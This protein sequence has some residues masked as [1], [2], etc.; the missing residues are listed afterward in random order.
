M[1]GV[2]EAFYDERQDLLHPEKAIERRV[3]SGE[4]TEVSPG[5]YRQTT[6]WDTYETFTL[7]SSG[8]LVPQHNLDETTG[9]VALAYRAGAPV[10]HELGTPIPVGTTD[11]DTVLKLGH[12]GWTVIQRPVLFS[13]EDHTATFVDAVEV[14]GHFVNLRDDTYVPLGVVGSVYKPFQN[15]DAM[16]FLQDLTGTF[17]LTWES[18]GATRGGRRVFVSVSLPDTVVI[19][20]EGIH[21]EIEL[22]IAVI[23]SHDGSSPLT[24][25]VTPW[26]P[27]CGN[28]ERFAVRDAVYRW[29]TRHTKNAKARTDEARRTLGLTLKYRARFA[30]EENRLAQNA[31]LIDEFRELVAEMFPRDEQETKVSKTK[32]DNREEALTELYG[33]NADRLGRTAYAAERAFTE[34]FD[35]AAPRKLL[36]GTLTAARATAIIEGSDDEK[37]TKVHKALL[38]RVS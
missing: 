27:V 19:D 10:W 7:S 30:E 32:R 23:N 38:Q 33:K 8:L 13:T 15:R 37:K 26:R 36:G 25:V 1:T 24:A 3:A 6:G 9:N 31:M 22:F 34:Y 11:I 14:P 18:V 28:T 20:P 35:N 12:V 16:E 5:V 2:N 21:D 4:L 29:K 17:D